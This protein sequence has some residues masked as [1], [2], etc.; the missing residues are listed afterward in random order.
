MS[1]ERKYWINYKGAQAG[2][3]SIEELGRMS[4]DA[5]AFVWHN[6]LT[7]WVR[8]SKVP[9]LAELFTPQVGETAPAAID[10]EHETEPVVAEAS[11]TPQQ[12]AI[13]EPVQTVVDSATQELAAET[14]DSP[15]AETSDHDIPEVP[16]RETVGAAASIADNPA[17]T[18]NAPL[19]TAQQFPQ[20]G[21]QGPSVQQPQP[22][23]YQAQPQFGIPQPGPQPVQPQQP[24]APQAAMPQKPPTNLGWAIAATILCCLP[25][26]IAAI[27]M[28]T[29]VNKHYERGDY[30]KALMWSERTA[31]TTIA[32][33]VLYFVTMPLQLLFSM[34]IH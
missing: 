11:A 29:Q 18:Q 33:I 30:K 17:A 12:V 25:I 31:W 21:V 24:I 15:A 3:L 16:I 26:G 2:P 6:G 4:I 13:D 28:S 34:V 5:T 27:I 22:Y 23:P 20:Q 19:N 14:G 10:A 1:T 32:S 8:I 9:E 7:D